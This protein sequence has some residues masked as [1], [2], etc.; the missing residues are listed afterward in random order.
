MAN[1]EASQT[2][3]W[4][5]RIAWAYVL[6]ICVLSLSF[7]VVPAIG[8]GRLLL[9][10]AW[11]G[12]DI[13]PAVLEWHDALSRRI[14]PWALERVASGR[15][16]SLDKYEVSGNEWPLLSA[17][18]YLWSS[19]AVQRQWQRQHSPGIAPAARDAEYIAA[20]A[21]LVADPGHAGWVRAHWGDAYLDER[22]LFYRMMLV[23]GL[24]S[25]ERL[26][27]DSRYHEL[28]ETQVRSLSTELD[29]SPHGLLED[30][31]G[32]TY[33]VDVAL[34]YAALARA[35]ERLDIADDG[36]RA[37]TARAFG[38]ALH[39]PEVSLP[40]YAVSADEG[41]PLGPARGVGLSMMLAWTPSLWPALGNDWYARYA[42]AFWQ[43]RMG[44]AGF[45]EF[46]AAPDSPD[47]TF[48]IDAGPVLAGYGTAASAL[49]LA[50]TRAH[51]DME[52]AYAL[53]SEA[54]LAAW[55]LPNGTLLGPRILS[56]AIDA[57]YTG[58]AALLFAL[59]RTPPDGAAAATR[60]TPP[61]VWIVLALL[62]LIGIGDPAR[63]V[64]RLLRADRTGQRVA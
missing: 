21:A 5:R 61:G 40:A 1:R 55:P 34:A 36:W 4:R 49:G 22:N 47:W 31:P 52:R 30:Y 38:V 7:I 6:A 13:A 53:T 15:A 29:A 20:A 2:P 14:G 62:L 28:L 17:V 8:V 45:R 24:D 16:G 60:A 37:R 3:R 12:S 50:A 9:D 10:P 54:L 23:A 39:D 41:V 33:S 44:F 48:E 42:G 59:T 18:M 26:G 35:R 57:P 56:N 32:E 51:G 25:F 11:R 43:E 19:E 63:R 46:A 58:E 64:V 27:G